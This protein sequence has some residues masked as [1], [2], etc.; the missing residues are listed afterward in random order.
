MLIIYRRR[1]WTCGFRII[2]LSNRLVNIL[3]DRISLIMSVTLPP[4]TVFTTTRL[5]IVLPKPRPVIGIIMR[6]SINREAWQKEAINHQ[7][8][9]NFTNFNKN[10]IKESGWQ[11]KNIYGK[12]MLWQFHRQRRYTRELMTTEN[13][14]LNLFYSMQNDNPRM[15]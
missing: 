5:Q 9:I 15:N 6:N 13:N 7:L 11:T 1:E 12:L 3:Y 2:L 4:T 14:R 8:L 10:L